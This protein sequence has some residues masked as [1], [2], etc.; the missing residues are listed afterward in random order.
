MKNHFSGEPADEGLLTGVSEAVPRI[1]RF[2]M[3]GLVVAR[4]DSFADYT[5][6]MRSL[7]LVSPLPMG[8]QAGDIS[9]QTCAR[10]VVSMARPLYD[11]DVAVLR[12]S[13]MASIAYDVRD[14]LM[15]VI[16]RVFFE[17]LNSPHLPRVGVYEFLV[18]CQRVG[19]TGGSRG[20][21][22]SVERICKDLCRTPHG[23]ELRLD[24]DLWA[25]FQAG[26]NQT[27]EV[28]SN[29]NLIS[30]DRAHRSRSVIKNLFDALNSLCD[31][32]L[33]AFTTGEQSLAR[34]LKNSAKY[35]NIFQAEQAQSFRKAVK[36]MSFALQ[37]FD[38]LSEPLFKIFLHFPSVLRFLGALTRDGDPEDARWSRR[39][40]T[41][42]T[43][44]QGFRKLMT[45]ALAS[46][47]LMMAQRF[48]RQDD[49]ADTE[50]FLKLGE[51]RYTTKLEG[52]WV[53]AVLT[54]CS[55]MQV[56]ELLHSVE[57]M[58][59][60]HCIFD[61]VQAPD[62]VTQRTL[63]M[64]NELG[65]IP[66]R[67][68]G[69]D[70]VC[71]IPVGE[72]AELHDVAKQIHELFSAFVNTNFPGYEQMNAFAALRL[73]RTL[74]WKQRQTL[75]SKQLV[76]PSTAA[77]S[78]PS[79]GIF[80][81]ALWFFKNFA[82]AGNVPGMQ[83][84]LD[85]YGASSAAWIRTL[86]DMTPQQRRDRP[87]A[88]QLIIKALTVQCGTQSVER[89]LGEV[90]LAELKHRARALGADTLE[91]S[92]KLNVQDF[93]GRQ[94]GKAFNPDSLFRS[95]AESIEKGVRYRA[96]NFGLQCQ[97]AYRR[98]YGEKQ[99]P[100]R[101]LLPSSARG[102]DH[103]E[104]KPKLTRVR[105][106]AGPAMETLKQAKD[107]HTKS[108]SQAVAAASKDTSAALGA[109]VQAHADVARARLDAS[110]SASS[111]RAQPDD[112]KKLCTVGDILNEQSALQQKNRQLVQS[113]PSQEPVPY[114]DGAGRQ[115]RYKLPS[116]P[117]TSLLAP[118]LPEKI[119]FICDAAV[120]LP[121]WRRYI[122]AGSAEDAHAALVEDLSASLYSPVALLARLH[123]LRLVDKVWVRSKM[124]EGNA[125][126][127]GPALQMHLYL[128]LA[129]SFFEKHPEHASILMAHGA[130]QRLVVRRGIPPSP[131]RHPRL[132]F[133]VTAASASSSSSSAI[134]ELDLEALLEKL[135]SLM[136]PRS[137]E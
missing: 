95:A 127:F 27:N 129:D 18:G 42:V 51:A 70:R 44:L 98:L 135:T 108:V 5:E 88:V 36:N 49:R 72:T 48:L 68:G 133:L 94:P 32:L 109:V 71:S 59:A 137:A 6:Y 131:P 38:S 29:M 28:F 3:A 50:V 39:L 17:G 24:E 34:M 97:N 78:E 13:T 118:P 10:L 61:A 125:L 77:G 124:R 111:K 102:S 91:S 120:R 112:G 57:I 35:S 87:L 115:Y 31:N 114:V 65:T 76:G 26:G 47:A 69:K 33:S 60:D 85:Q 2:F 126:C 8:E 56:L 1:D 134:A 46:D 80:A 75:M 63:R 54:S 93:T 64:L 106:T 132:T 99:D 23:R 37:R 19:G 53:V 40:L 121:V 103:H 116:A 81:R 100:G 73:D 92:V 30:R 83:R 12:K 105:K 90:R 119:R 66:F 130:Q 113:L 21:A 79:S 89:Y 20:S 117:K 101:S 84:M 74:S 104:G 16:G 62:T 136:Q 14:D 9:K 96:S 58:F 11:H 86:G 110:T 15:L 45:A 122:L 123:G 67:E 22:A 43:G 25:H 7:R 55:V 41:Q 82:T 128:Y 107:M 52:S 4:H